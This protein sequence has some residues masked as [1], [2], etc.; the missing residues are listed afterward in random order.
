MNR[1][2]NE[3][4]DDNDDMFDIENYDNNN[5]HSDDNNKDSKS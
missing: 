2:N 4:I 5:G 3:F 1:N